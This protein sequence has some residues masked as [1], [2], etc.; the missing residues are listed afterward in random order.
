MPKRDGTGPMGDGPLTGWGFGD[1]AVAPG[2]DN[3]S[4][5]MGRGPGRGSGRRRGFGGG[6]G[7]GRMAGRGD[8]F[9]QPN[10]KEEKHLLENQRNILK[11]QLSG[12]T[13]RLDELTAL[14]TQGK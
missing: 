6:M 5:A 13:S 10:P 14:E 12:L 1:C 8:S 3:T 9:A 11:S 2:S 7:R 4:Q